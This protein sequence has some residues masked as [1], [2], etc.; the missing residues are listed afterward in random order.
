MGFLA[1]GVLSLVM[2]AWPGVDAPGGH[3]L[4]ALFGPNE[5]MIGGA[6][7]GALVGFFRR[8]RPD[9]RFARGRGERGD[10]AGRRDARVVGQFESRD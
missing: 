4:V 3:Y 8:Q 1:G 2:V 10:R 7:F 6:A 9:P 5:A